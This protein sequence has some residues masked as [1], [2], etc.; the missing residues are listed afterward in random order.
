MD[1]AVLL[2]F[3]PRGEKQIRRL[4]HYLTDHGVNDL[5][6]NLG[7]RPHLTLAEFN[8][9]DFDRVAADLQRFVIRQQ[10]FHL[11]FS[12][13]GLFPAEHGVLFLAPIVDEPLLAFHRELNS[14]LE[15]LCHEFSPL[16]QEA[17]WVAHCTLVLEMGPLEIALAYEALLNHFHPLDTWT[18]SLAVISCCPY[19]ECLEIPFKGV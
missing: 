9:S 7:M 6:V 17:S 19:Q 15:P 10:S 12:S 13:L 3:E 8:T 16:Y 18:A 5:Y 11:R 2:Y 1:Y 4:M 14:L